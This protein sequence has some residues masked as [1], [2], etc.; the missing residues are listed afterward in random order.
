MTST[1]TILFFQDAIEMHPCSQKKSLTLSIYF[2][3]KKQLAAY[4]EDCCCASVRVCMSICFRRGAIGW[5]C[6]CS[7]ALY[8]DAH[9]DRARHLSV[10]H[11]EGTGIGYDL[12][13][14][15]VASFLSPVTPWAGKWTPFLDLRGH[16]FNDGKAAANAGWGVRYLTP[17]R[18]LGSHI[19][20]DYR[21]TAH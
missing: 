14:T 6:L 17:S 11:T 16:V 2:L 1:T 20:Y 5:A 19:Y 13:Y 4:P 18:V 21:N 9:V 3:V 7:A 8:A 12:G 10:R 15:T